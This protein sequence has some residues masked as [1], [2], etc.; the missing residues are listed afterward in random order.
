M[1]TKLL[2]KLCSWPKT[3]WS[4]YPTASLA[5]LDQNLMEIS[6][7]TVYLARKARDKE[8]YIK[9]YQGSSILKLSLHQNG[10]IFLYQQLFYTFF[11]AM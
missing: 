7:V 8:V 10:P 6:Q 2:R 9:Q 4:S 3:Y 11:S 5:S 1:S